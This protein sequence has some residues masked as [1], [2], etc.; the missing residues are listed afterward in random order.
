MILVCIPSGSETWFAGSSSPFSSMIKTE[1]RHPPFLMGISLATF[2]DT[3]RYMKEWR[4]GW[5][6]TYSSEK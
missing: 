4:S 5:W 2:D 6:Y 1:I 3:K